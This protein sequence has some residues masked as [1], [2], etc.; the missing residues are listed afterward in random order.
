MAYSPLRESRRQLLTSTKAHQHA[1]AGRHPQTPWCFCSLTPLDSPN[2]LQ[3][4]HENF[5]AYLK[6]LEAATTDLLERR[7]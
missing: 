5:Q 2:C 7:A 3:C 1:C 6:D 4:R